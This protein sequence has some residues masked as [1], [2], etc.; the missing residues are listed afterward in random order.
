M[1]ALSGNTAGL[2]LSRMCAHTESQR[3]CARPPASHLTRMR[4]QKSLA[5]SLTPS[6]DL[7]L[8]FGCSV[9]IERHTSDSAGASG[10]VQSSKGK[11]PESSCVVDDLL[12]LAVA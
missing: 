6:Q 1:R 12:V 7:P 2:F 4:R 10:L 8:N 5:S 9:R 11:R 3:V